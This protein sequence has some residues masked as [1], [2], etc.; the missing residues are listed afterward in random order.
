MGS[1]SNCSFRDP[2]AAHR[3]TQTIRHSSTQTLRH[4]D[5]QALRHSGRHWGTQTLR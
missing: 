1:L 2:H 5:T 3:D 4:S